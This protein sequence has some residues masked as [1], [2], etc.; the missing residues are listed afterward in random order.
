MKLDESVIQNIM[1]T[2]GIRYDAS[3][4]EYIK[5]HLRSLDLVVKPGDS[6]QSTLVENK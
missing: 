1:Q 4:S 3:W 5:Q 6:S 2:V